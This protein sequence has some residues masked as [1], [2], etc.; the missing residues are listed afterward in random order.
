MTLRILVF[1]PDADDFR[2][3]HEVLSHAGL[4]DH[5]L[6]VR[7]H[8]D[9]MTSLRSF[10]PDVIVVDAART[11][12]SGQQALLWSRNS[13]EFGHVP[14]ILFTEP[15][16]DE[17][18][19]RALRSG[20]SDYL[21][22]SEIERLPDAIRYA[23]R[24]R[25]E[26]ERQMRCQQ[27]LRHAA[28]QIRENQKLVTIG[29]LTGMI[30]HE[31]NNP[32]AAIANI[33]YLLRHEGSQS[34]TATAY[35]DLAERELARVVQISRQTLS[36]YRESPTPE[37]VSPTSL[38]EE[39]LELYSRKLKEKNIQVRRRYN[40]QGVI[41]LF[42]GEMRQVLSNLVSNAIEAMEPGGMLTVHVY[43]MHRWDTS[44]VPGV[45]I[46][47][48]DTGSGI[49]VDKLQRIGEPFFTTKGQKGTGLGLWVSQG[50]IRKY[51]GDL[52]ISSSTNPRHHGTVFS[53]FLPENTRFR[54]QNARKGAE[55]GA[56]NGQPE[57]MNA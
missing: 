57:L 48:A 25:E 54:E 47:V 1:E 14:I 28:E 50:I 19:V 12:G 31:I 24:T 43:R 37:V 52:Q 30:T 36:F 11:G 49:P 46:V 56:R 44:R 32:L 53:I 40:F 16:G 10:S 6:Q 45:R 27:E 26:N 2:S 42:P 51:G 13:D 17:A 18:A 41:S 55:S 35:L 4:S 29:R 22:K 3:M 38:M 15:Q 33:L 8:T 39:V 9:F 34:E 5:L 20:A 21:V 7:S 23:V